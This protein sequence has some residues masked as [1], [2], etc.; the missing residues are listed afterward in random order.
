MCLTYSLLALWAPGGAVY[1]DEQY[2]KA[3]QIVAPDGLSTKIY[4]EPSKTSEIL[5]VAFNG[6]IH[7][8]VGK[9]KGFVE[10]NLPDAGI[11]GFV[12]EEHTRPWAPPRDKGLSPTVLLLIGVGAAILILAGIVLFFT[13]VRKAKAAEVRAASIPVSIKRAE[14][15]FREGDYS[16]A[17]KEFKNYVDMQGGEVRNPDV[18]RRLSVCY[19]K[20]GEYREA[21]RAWE[22]MRSLGGLRDMDDHALGVALMMALGKEAEAAE[23]YEELLNSEEDPDI[24]MDIHAKL[25]HTY[26]RLK[27]PV[28]LLTHADVLIDSE[29]VGETVLADTIS[30]FVTEGQTDRAIQSNNKALVK[31]I[32]EELLEMKAKTPEAARVYMK[33]L[34][35]DRTDKRLHGMMSQIYQEQ[36]NYRKAVSELTI[37]YQLDRGQSDEF[38]DQA[39]RIYVENGM[40][41]EALAQGNPV[42]IK[43]I[44]QIYLARSEVNP[45]AVAVYEKVLELQPKAVGINK[46]L[47]TVYLTRGDLEAYMRRLRVLHEIDGRNH[48]YLSDLARCIVDNDLV[49][50]SIKEGNRDLN[51]R[52]LR[53]LIRQKAS[54]D[55]TVTLFEKLLR[56]EPGNTPIRGALIHAYE[57]RGEYG[58]ALDHILTMS[59]IKPDEKEFVAKAA[60]IAVKHNLIAKIVESG[61]GTVA[62]LTAAHVVKNK[63]DGP[64]CRQILEIALRRNPKDSNIGGYLK[65]LKPV[66]SKGEAPPSPAVQA[67]AKKTSPKPAPEP[68]TTPKPPQ[69]PVTTARPTKTPAST[70][71]SP[72]PSATAPKPAPVKPTAPAAAR[73]Q[74]EAGQTQHVRS[75]VKSRPAGRTGPANDRGK[76]AP[77]KPAPAPRKP[78]VRKAPP[79]TAPEG[80]PEPPKSPRRPD[81]PEP[82]P[83]VSEARSAPQ[84]TKKPP[85]PQPAPQKPP[86]EDRRPPV[87]FVDLTNKDISFEEKA[88]T[89]F[90]SGYSKSLAAKYNREELFLPAT[91][92]FAYK[93]M[94]VL[95]SDGWGNTHLG[96]EVNTGR[97]VLMRVFRKNLMEPPL[98]KEFIHQISELG[99]NIVHDSV[100]P[101]QETVLGPGGAYGLVHP[102]YPRNLELAM[103]PGKPLNL[104]KALGIFKKLLDGLS[105]AHNFKGL[106]GKLRRTFH[107]HMHPSQVLVSDD[108]SECRIAS[109]GYSQVFRNMTRASRPRWQEPGMNPATM[110][111]EF[112]RARTT[113]VRERS[114]EVYSLGALLHFMVTGEFP[115]EGPSFDDY[116]FQ[117][118]R[119]IATPP[120]LT[121]SDLP[122]WIDHVVL[123]CLEKEPDKRWNSVFE[124]QKEFTDG[125]DRG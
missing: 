16:R 2:P 66:A 34:E 122:E 20:V 47:S 55:K 38:M 84:P 48:D 125:M 67:T 17:L 37:L 6:G 105:Y 83:P 39:A 64:E 60:G 106:D 26:R 121:V 27:E 49:E 97:G 101:L 32:C 23:I 24:R 78:A 112:F 88:V 77:S 108:L 56:V 94:E 75:Q 18:Y 5:D 31:G 44:A 71:K 19:Q 22:K 118:T 96:I 30:F 13:K 11:T 36:G 73:P 76:T 68:A 46:M 4:S 35:Y 93:D 115:F 107:L 102:H 120:S 104:D 70:P 53:Q 54:D 61:V 85:E 21:A 12:L 114:S 15:C 80:T 87:Q 110:P 40:V 111:P 99:F 33:A 116:K 95:F 113:G 41:P 7:E 10:I 52:I 79:G 42:I 98:M 86:S 28:K 81:R 109:L 69:E 89:T 58:N 9:R 51:S 82:A 63:M 72:T 50:E 45:D 124:L 103:E 74:P 90:V 91:G 43:K 59:K 117:H 62:D 14:E 3:I 100:L 123:G 65:S 1:A 29:K 92:G 25:F 57:Q 119:I 8:V